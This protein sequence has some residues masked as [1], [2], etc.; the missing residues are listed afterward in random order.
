MRRGSAGSGAG[1]EAEFGKAQR[2]VALGSDVGWGSGGGV[3][4][5]EGDGSRSKPVGKRPS[6]DGTDRPGGDGVTRGS[7]AVIAFGAASGV[8][9]GGAPV[10]DSGA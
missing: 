1:G 9:V 7:G 8:R 6:G 4:M 3:E 2:L 5:G 10:A